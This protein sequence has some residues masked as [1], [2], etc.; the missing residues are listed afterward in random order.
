MGTEGL[1]YFRRGRFSSQNFLQFTQVRIYI[2]SVRVGGDGPGAH[3]AVVGLLG[4]VEMDSSDL[5][6]EDG[7]SRAALYIDELI[8]A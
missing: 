1:W 8:R 5:W 6:G 4:K 2:S 3:V 7:S